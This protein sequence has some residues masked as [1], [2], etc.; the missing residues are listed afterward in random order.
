MAHAEK[1]SGDGVLDSNVNRSFR[2][3]SY[4]GVIE[5]DIDLGEIHLDSHDCLNDRA[6]SWPEV[7]CLVCIEDY[8]SAKG[9]IL[10]RL[11]N[12]VGRFKRIGMFST[13]ALMG[14]KRVL[15]GIRMRP[16]RGSQSFERTNVNYTMFSKNYLG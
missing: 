14:E 11:S 9:L 13:G 6:S 8:I 5:N 2:L 15:P 7:Y 1:D 10:V 4:R 12:G 3:R 16:L